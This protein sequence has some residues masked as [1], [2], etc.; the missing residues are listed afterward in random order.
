MIE[1]ALAQDRERGTA[2]RAARSA[3]A[4]GLVGALG[5]EL[6][7]QLLAS[8]DYGAVHVGV[9]QPIGSAAARFRPWVVGHGVVVAD[10][11]FVGLTGPETFVPKAS[12][13]QAFGPADTLIAARIARETGASRLVLVAPLAALLQM[14][15]AAQ[16]ISNDAEMEIV[17]MGFA[18]V[19]I[20]RPTAADDLRPDAHWL[21]GLVRTIGRTLADLMLPGYARAL[22]A[23]SAARAIFEAARTA[24]PGVTVLG[25]RELLAIVEA[26][27][28]SLAPKRRRLR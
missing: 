15:A 8:G 18:S 19:V 24:R 22:S 9:S 21:Q 13:V 28:P 12:P 16:A 2:P 26:K 20:V 23:R 14:S 10:D 3:L 6:L 7:S 1:S 11:V 4:L 25:A 17:R 27:F 5:E